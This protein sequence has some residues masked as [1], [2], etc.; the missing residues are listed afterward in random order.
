MTSDDPMTLHRRQ[1][2]LWRRCGYCAERISRVTIIRG[3]PC[4]H[5]GNEVHSDMNIDA[6]TVIEDVTQSW[7]RWRWVIYPAAFMA[8][9]LGGWIPFVHSI[10]IFI[11]LVGVH[12]LIVRHPLRWLSFG[13]RMTTR[14]TVKL[15]VAFFAVMNF[16]LDV[17]L[18][19]FIGLNAIVLSMVA[20]LSVFL[21]TE[22]MILLI[23]NRLRRDAISSRLD[24][25]EWL[26]PLTLIGL[27][28]G[29]TGAV[30]SV[31]GT[32]AYLLYSL[33]IPSVTDVVDSILSWWSP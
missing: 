12:L 22:G 23:T 5:C 16:L 32:M 30:T 20:V 19:P 8:S 33:E 18:I 25:W 14:F 7:K 21:Y 6:E 11:A 24:T 31:L 26:V 28:V 10:L 15:F 9:L 4:P 3:G 2:L 29:A 1:L 27:I 13:R 17:L